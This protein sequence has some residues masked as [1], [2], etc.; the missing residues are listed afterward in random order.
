M[1]EAIDGYTLYPDDFPGFKLLHS[2]TDKNLAGNT[3]YMIE[4]HY[5]DPEFGKQMLLEQGTIKGNINYYIQYFATPSQYLN[6]L[7]D[8]T[9]M[10]D[11]FEIQNK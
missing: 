7:D 3:A 4:G 1:N 5:K 6:Y 10:I 2:S 11:S 9:T 8:V